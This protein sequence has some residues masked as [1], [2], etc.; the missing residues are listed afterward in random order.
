MTFTFEIET[1]AGGKPFA[2]D[3]GTSL[4]FVGA[5]GGGKTRLAVKIEELLGERA[6]RIG[7]HRALI[8][9]PEVAKV[10]ERAALAS[11]R[12]GNGNINAT[13]RQRQGYRW[14]SNGAVALL[15]DYDF[16]VQALFADQANTS[17]RTHQNARAGG[18]GPVTPTKFERLVEIWNRI[19]PQR[20]LHISGDDVRAGLPGQPS[21]YA[22]SEMSDGERAIFYLIGQ[23]LLAAPESLI[24]FDEPELHVHRAVMARLWDELEAARADCALVV[25]SHDLEFVASREGQKFVIRDYLPDTGWIIEDVPVDSGFSEEITTLILG[26]RKPILFVE[27]TNGSLDQAIYRACYP[28]W[29]VIPRGACE[30]VIHA[31]VTMRANAGLTRITCAGIV[32]ADDYQTVEQTYLSGKGVAVLPVSEIE[33]LFML[34]PVL[35]AVLEVEGYRGDALASRR[36]DLLDELF[37]LASDTKAQRASILRYCRRRI[38]RALKRVDLSDAPDVGSLA[39]AY[40]A[41]TAAI[42]VELL[43]Q[44]AR[45]AIETAI[46]RRDAEQL[47]RWFDNKGVLAI[48]AKAKGSG[49]P[50]FEQWLVRTMRNNAAPELTSAIETYLPLVTPQ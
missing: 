34:P 5:N 4:F 11:L 25:I 32:D 45:S 43:A 30:E 26:S 48:A 6:H 17:L 22:A 3:P 29:T 46:A 40:A 37:A 1:P 16:V 27:G 39:S 10:S 2:V 18:T 33:N 38:D 20:S 49:K 42:D 36:A 24:I 21:L 41:A 15:S 13:I 50:H 19:L 31:V 44:T 7:A 12:I 35:T 14:G 28:E 8:L 23:T 9:N 47:L